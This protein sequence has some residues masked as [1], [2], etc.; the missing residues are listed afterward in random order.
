MHRGRR[1]GKVDAGAVAKCSGW[2]DRG[3]VLDECEVALEFERRVLEEDVDV[4]LLVAAG[5]EGELV[6]VEQDGAED[7]EVEVRQL[8]VEV[9]AAGRRRGRRNR[10]GL[11]DDGPLGCWRG[12]DA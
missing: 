12:N 8:A 4:K 10:D 6:E 1:Q 7:F 2:N 3:E 5:A 9:E 11:R